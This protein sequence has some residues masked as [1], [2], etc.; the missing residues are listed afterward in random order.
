MLFHNKLFG[1]IFVKNI[2]KNILKIQIKRTAALSLTL[3]ISAALP[4]FGST[5]YPLNYK[6]STLYAGME[7]IQF[8]NVS[9]LRMDQVVEY[10]YNNLPDESFSEFKYTYR[11]RIEEDPFDIATYIARRLDSL[12]CMI[13]FAQV[14]LTD[15]STE[16]IIK[17]CENEVRAS[18]VVN[19]KKNL[20]ILSSIIKEDSKKAQSYKTYEVAHVNRPYTGKAPD[21]WY[22]VWSLAQIV[23]DMCEYDTNAYEQTK[24][25]NSVAFGMDLA[26]VQKES[27]ETSSNIASSDNKL[28]W[29][30]YGLLLKKKA[31]CAG[32]SSLTTLTLRELGIP[33][34]KVCGKRNTND[35]GYHSW[36]AVY[37]E[38]RWLFVDLTNIVGDGDITNSPL[39][40][41]TQEAF[42]KSGYIW[43]E[44]DVESDIQ[45]LYPD[46]YK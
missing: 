35:D 26:S 15:N 28:A 37:M 29:S 12:K 22:K 39:V 3:A 45:I 11:C 17:P 34:I 13:Y 21:T 23:T 4:V 8:S 14:K 46:I 43:C 44:R 20:E 32:I 31:V 10:L 2:L 6:Q 18:K 24:E 7:A 38:G 16:I 30:V 41:D 33:A 19:L 5:S 27:K 36:N 40:F 25:S 42:S 1:G 9:I